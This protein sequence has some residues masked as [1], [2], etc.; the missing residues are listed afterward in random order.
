LFAPTITAVVRNIPHAQCIDDTPQDE[1]TQTDKDKSEKP[2]E[3]Q[4]AAA[5][6]KVGPGNQRDQQDHPD[7]YSIE[8][9]NT[10]SYPLAVFGDHTAKYEEYHQPG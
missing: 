9:W 7:G 4:P 2:G 6:T 8:D 1:T 5:K 10:L 3:Q